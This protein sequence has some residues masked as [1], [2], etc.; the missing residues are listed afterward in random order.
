[1]YETLHQRTITIEIVSIE[2][3]YSLLYEHKKNKSPIQSTLDG[4]IVS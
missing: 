2:K 4:V 3:R 1:M